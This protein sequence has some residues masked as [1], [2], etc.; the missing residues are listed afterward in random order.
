MY[1]NFYIIF[2]LTY[3]YQ[4]NFFISNLNLNELTNLLNN[5]TQQTPQ[6]R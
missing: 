3:Q 4:I 6:H 5:N 1:A 2:R